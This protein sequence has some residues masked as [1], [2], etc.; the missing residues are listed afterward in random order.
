[1]AKA[2]EPTSP[3]EALFAF[4]GWLSTRSTPVTLGATHEASIAADIVEEFRLSQG[5]EAPRDG[6]ENLLKDYP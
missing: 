5:W 1:M 6:W 3:S 4:A 2:T